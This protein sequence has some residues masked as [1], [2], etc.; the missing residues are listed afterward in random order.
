MEQLGKGLLVPDLIDPDDV[1]IDNTVIV[2]F[3]VIVLRAFILLQHDD[4]ES[5]LAQVPFQLVQYLVFPGGEV[6]RLV[7][8][9]YPL[10]SEVLSE[11]QWKYRDG[12]ETPG[13]KCG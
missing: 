2:G 13:E 6:D 5:A 1:T 9:L 4:G 11:I 3:E 8:Y 7:C 10:K 12:E